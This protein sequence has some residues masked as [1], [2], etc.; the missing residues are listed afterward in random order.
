MPAEPGQPARPP[1]PDSAEEQPLDPAK[2]AVIWFSSRPISRP[3]PPGPAA[4]DGEADGRAGA[5]PGDP[6]APA[7]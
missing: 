2:T 6:G 3:V 7:G 5:Q 4:H 1:A